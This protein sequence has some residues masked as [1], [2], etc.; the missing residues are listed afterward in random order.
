MPFLCCFFGFRLSARV[1][2]LSC[3]LCDKR[4]NPSSEKHFVRMEHNLLID[5]EP[6]SVHLA[7]PNLPICLALTYSQPALVTGATS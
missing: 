3:K 6:T 4:S 5:Q 1:S 7:R 2:G